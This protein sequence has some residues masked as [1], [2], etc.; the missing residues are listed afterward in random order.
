[1]FYKLLDIYV[2]ELRIT[3]TVTAIGNNKRQHVSTAH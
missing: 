3:A 2:T 1:M